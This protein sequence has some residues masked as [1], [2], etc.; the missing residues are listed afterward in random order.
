MVDRYVEASCVGLISDF[1]CGMDG[2]VIFCFLPLKDTIVG[3]FVDVMV[4]D[5]ALNVWSRSRCHERILAIRKV[6]PPGEVAGSLSGLWLGLSSDFR[7]EAS[8]KRAREVTLQ[9]EAAFQ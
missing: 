7:I 2:V 9:T 8:W 3:C 6:W 1:E 4:S 5:R